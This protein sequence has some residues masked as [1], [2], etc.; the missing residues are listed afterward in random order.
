MSLLSAIL[1]WLR[2]APVVAGSSLA[3]EPLS[4]G[5]KPNNDGGFHADLAPLGTAPSEAD[6][7]R[8]A[9]DR[10]GM[11]DN[12]LRA[13]IAAIAM[14]ESGMKGHVERGYAGTSNLRIRQIFGARVAGLSEQDLDDLKRDERAFFERVYGSG[15][16]IGRQ[17]GNMMP[18]DGWAFRGRGF[19]QLTGRGNYARY[20][21]AIGKRDA[22]LANP[23]LAN[24]PET[25]AALT[26]AYIKDRY[27][28][29]GWGPLVACVG[30]NTSDIRARKDAYFARFKAS[31]EF[32]A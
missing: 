4:T 27:R 21:E 10:A 23:D 29:G 16:A 3:A 1:S 17:L 25:S 32:N 30:N 19:I 2:P 9:M 7:L 6:L 28:G 5:R 8:A 20:G 31:G 22:L 12:D 14:G 24:A 18:G 15:N 13:G 11:T 26:V